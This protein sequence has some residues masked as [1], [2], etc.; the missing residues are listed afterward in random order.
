MGQGPP[1]AGVRRIDDESPENYSLDA[2]RARPTC[3][4]SVA[5]AVCYGS[6]WIMISG[7]FSLTLVDGAL[8]HP[9][10]IAHPVL[11]APAG[12]SVRPSPT[13]VPGRGAQGVS[14]AAEPA[15]GACEPLTRP[16]TPVLSAGRWADHHARQPRRARRSQP[17]CPSTRVSGM[18]SCSLSGSRR[19]A[20]YSVAQSRNACT[21]TAQI[22]LPAWK[23]G[24]QL[25]PPS[26][27]PGPRGSEHSVS[28]L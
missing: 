9:M 6:H 22:T 13:R 11:E 26:V 20:A 12:G 10:A 25:A 24:I 16:S 19:R 18:P 5:D 23:A 28:H 15:R 14:R 8:A 4:R 21:P 17:R 1:A 27:L 2:P 7:H 3:R